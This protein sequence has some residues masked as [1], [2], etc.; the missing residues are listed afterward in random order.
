MY[1]SDRLYDEE[2]GQSGTV[3]ANKPVAEVAVSQAREQLSE[4]VNRAGYGHET[5]YLTR[6]GRRIAALVPLCDAE[7][8]DFGEVPPEARGR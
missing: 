5:I 7:P 4:I 2:T 1:K 3:E 8:K 6:H